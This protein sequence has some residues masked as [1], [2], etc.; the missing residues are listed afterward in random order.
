M[1]ATVEKP[2]RLIFGTV[3][4][5]DVDVLREKIRSV[6]APTADQRGEKSGMGVQ[7]E[8]SNSGS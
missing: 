3:R 5:F 4:G 8:T 2:R 7:E 1:S 6:E